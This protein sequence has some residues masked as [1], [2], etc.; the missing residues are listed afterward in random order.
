M[1]GQ[2][3]QR[4]IAKAL[5]ASGGVQQFAG[6]VA[7]GNQRLGVQGV[8]HRHQHAGEVGMS[9]MLA[10][11]GLHQQGVVGR[12]SQLAR[13]AFGVSACILGVAGRAHAGQAAQGPDTQAGV[14]G[15]GCALPQLR[16]M[17]RLGQ[18]VF[19][20]GDVG[21]GRLRDAQ[22]ALVDQ[23]QPQRPQQGLQLFELLGVVGGEDELHDRP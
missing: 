10:Q 11:H 18:G 23:G 16:G 9:V 19:D 21:L 15:D 5:V 17:A 1:V 20:E 3:Q 2:P 4:V 22:G 8:A 12:I 13:H 14:V 7:F 6:P